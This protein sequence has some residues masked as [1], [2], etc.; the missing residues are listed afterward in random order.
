MEDDDL[1]E[2]KNLFN[3]DILK[4]ILDQLKER[5]FNK[6][7]LEEHFKEVDIKLLELREKMNNKNGKRYNKKC[8]FLKNRL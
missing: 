3:E 7:I 8:F 4:I 2:I 6:E 5:E 1:I